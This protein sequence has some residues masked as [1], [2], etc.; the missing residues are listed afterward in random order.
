ML[1]FSM[2]EILNL[3][4]KELLARSNVQ[5]GIMFRKGLSGMKSVLKLYQ[6]MGFDLS[7]NNKNSITSK[8]LGLDIDTSSDIESYI[9]KLSGAN[10]YTSNL[11]IE[12]YVPEH[13]FL[14]VTL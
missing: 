13:C 3:N 4:L 14:L 8:I 1:N 9:S 6:S 10:I 12:L 2:N 5:V 7:N 11:R